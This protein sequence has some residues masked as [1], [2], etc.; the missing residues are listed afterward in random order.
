MESEKNSTATEIAAI[1]SLE[2]MAGNEFSG[3]IGFGTNG[4]SMQQMAKFA[5][6]W[7]QKARAWDA[8]LEDIKK[9]RDRKPEEVSINTLARDMSY[10]HLLDLMNELSPPQPKD[11]LEELEEWVKKRLYI[12]PGILLDEIRRLRVKK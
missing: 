8:L 5:L 6:E 10:N 3:T 9:A 11:P 7:R 4:C 2:Q 1:E 12:D